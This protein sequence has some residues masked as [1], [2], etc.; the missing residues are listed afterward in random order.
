MLRKVS[1]GRV[2]Q[3]VV[4]GGGASR[5][6]E[7]QLWRT[8][9]EC[10][11]LIGVHL[12]SARVERETHLGA[13]ETKVGNLDAPVLADEDVVRLEVA[14]QNAPRVASGEPAQDL[15]RDQEGCAAG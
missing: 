1:E 11:N 14:V 4:V 12:I 8:V 3:L 15:R 10:H 5:C 13:C 9:I 2:S 6:A 7:K